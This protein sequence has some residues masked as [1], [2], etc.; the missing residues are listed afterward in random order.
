MLG[1]LKMCYTCLE[2][3]DDELIDVTALDFDSRT[4]L[5]KL[6]MCVSSHLDEH[7][8]KLLCSECVKQLRVSYKFRATVLLSQD[9][10]NKR[11]NDLLPTVYEGDPTDVLYKIAV[12]RQFFGSQCLIVNDPVD[13]NDLRETDKNKAPELPSN[14][15]AYFLELKSESA[16]QVDDIHNSQFTIA[17]L[18]NKFECSKC[19]IVAD[20][21]HHDCSKYNGGYKSAKEIKVKRRRVRVKRELAVLEDDITY[22]CYH[23]AT[24]FNKRWKLQKHITRVHTNVKKHIC[25]YCAKSFK[26]SYHLREHLTSHTGERNYTCSY[27]EKTFQRI[28]SLKRHS[29]SHERAPGE[30]TKKTPFLCTVCGKNFPFSNGV[31]RHMRTHLGIRNHECTVCHRRFTQSTHLHVHMRTHTGEKPYI[32]D[33]CGEAFPLNASLQKHMAIH[34]SNSDCDQLKM[35]PNCN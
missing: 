15:A 1:T 30:K 24:V 10:L 6:Q 33:T 2:I 17:D 25:P 32:C 27:C 28:S 29:R 12:H 18:I 5:Y 11:K 22:E 7:N 13:L 8:S 14:E 9:I 19:N 3:K 16:A 31:Q 34:K 26:Q 20:S 4:F 21:E 35:S 23:C